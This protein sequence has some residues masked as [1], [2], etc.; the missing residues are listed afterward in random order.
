[1]ANR[2]FS[3]MKTKVSTFIEDT[4]TTMLT[5]I[6]DWLN[7]KWQ[8]TWR[9]HDWSAKT[10]NDYTF[11]T[12]ANQ[13]E[14]NLPLDF[15][16]E[17]YLSNIEDGLPLRR[18]TEALWW[19]ERHSAY[20]ADSITASIFPSKYVVLREALNTT[21]TGFGKL[22][23]DPK[24]STVKTYAMPYTRKWRK[25]LNVTET[26]TTDTPLKVIA[27]AGTFV[28]DGTE[29]G[30][31]IH[32]TTDNV[33][34]YVVSV[35]SETQITADWDICPDGNEAVTIQ[36]LVI[37][38]DLDFILEYGAIAEAYAYKKFFQ[39]ADYYNMKYESELAKRIGQEK[40][41]PNQSYQF[42]PESPFGSGERR[43]TGDASY[44]SL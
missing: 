19:R 6:G 35:D 37:V 25:L 38:P 11:D 39:K 42:I 43:L 2:T 23:L 18:Y 17:L 14:Y 31:V 32:N 8:D 10:N 4:D 40:N 5:Y 26:C 44:D 3:Q 22:I 33:Y 20:L 24:P 41:K 28:T 7:D 34:G 1:M 9:R 12:V 36:N 27:S 15:G 16:D 21:H 30:M 13:A 29:P